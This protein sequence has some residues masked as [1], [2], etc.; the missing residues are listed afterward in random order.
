MKRTVDLLDDVAG[1]VKDTQTGRVLDFATAVKQ[2]LVK[3]DGQLES[4]FG[5]R[6][7]SH[8]IPS[9][10][11]SEGFGSPRLIERKLQLTP[12]AQDPQPRSS[13][14]RVTESFQTHSTVPAPF[15]G[16]RVAESY[17]THSTVPAPLGGSTERMVDLGGGKTVKVKCFSSKLLDY[18]NLK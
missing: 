3:E 10:P 5:E 17:Q 4:F 8:Q 6:S 2:G 7:R 15:G 9:R 13:S 18:S 1:T 16:S 11:I 12:Y 14:S